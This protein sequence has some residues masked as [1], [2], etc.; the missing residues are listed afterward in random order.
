MSFEGERETTREVR[1]EVDANQFSPDDGA[2]GL[3]YFLIFQIILSISVRTLVNLGVAVS[4]LG[5][6]LGIISELSFVLVVWYVASNSKKKFFEAISIKKKFSGWYILL[7][8]ATSFVSLFG[9][10]GATNFF[11]SLLYELG[12]ESVISDFAIDTFGKY[13]YYVI[14]IA[15]I[16]AICEEVLFRGLVYQSLRKISRPI[17]IFGS[18]F[19]FMLIH[20]SPDQTVHQFILAIILALSFEATGNILVPILIHFFNNFIAVTYTYISSFTAVEESAAASAEINLSVYFI[21]AV[22][23]AVVAS[24]IVF[25]IISAMRKI[26]KIEPTNEVSARDLSTNGTI[27]SEIMREPAQVVS[28][29]QDGRVVGERPAVAVGRLSSTGKLLYGLSIAYMALSWISACLNGFGMGI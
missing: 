9:F 13:V 29:E 16:P 25:L 7:A 15:I 19:L 11:M 24:F 5:I 12:Y 21:Y 27:V 23:S 22:I 8:L 6:V 18:S 10:S 4:I 20:G 2:K 1:P 17:A 28:I 3:F 14:S 26:S